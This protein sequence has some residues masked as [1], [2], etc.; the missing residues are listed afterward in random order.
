MKAPEP[1][2]PHTVLTDFYTTPEARAGFVNRLFDST[3]R[4]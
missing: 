1:Q 3:A 2:A 4:H